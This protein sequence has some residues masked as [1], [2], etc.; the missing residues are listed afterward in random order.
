[1]LYHLL[2]DLQD[3]F[4]WLNVI[5]YITFRGIISLLFSLTISLLLYPWFIRE[6]TKKQLGQVVRDDGP[7][8]HYSKSG[9]PTMGGLLLVL[10][11]AATSLLWMR[12]DNPSL[13]LCLALL[14]GYSFLGFKDDYEKISKN[15]TKGLSAKQKMFWQTALAAIVCYYNYYYIQNPATAGVINIPYT[16]H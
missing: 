16:N 9:T 14:L 5:K 15:N 7:K 12:W 11:V 13:W 2:L 8:S 1:M 4:S 6:I 10:S 3:H